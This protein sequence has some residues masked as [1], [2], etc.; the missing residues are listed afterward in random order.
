MALPGDV[1]ILAG[2]DE[3]RV[4]SFLVSRRARSV[5]ACGACGSL[6]HRILSILLACRHAVA[7]DHI[8]ITPCCLGKVENP[9]VSRWLSSFGT[10]DNVQK[11]H[12]WS[13]S[14][15]IVKDADERKR[16]A[17]ISVQNLA[18]WYNEQIDESSVPRLSVFEITN[19]PSLEQPYL[20]LSSTSDQKE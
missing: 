9:P 8:L 7:V 6:P 17:L 18:E 14:P 13:A 4:V 10:P 1:D 16:L 5:V 15:G 20:L 2:D 11:A 12:V 3:A 19:D